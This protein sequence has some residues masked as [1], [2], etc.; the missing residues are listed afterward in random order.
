[1]SDH[2]ENPTR[3]GARADLTQTI[4]RFAQPLH[5][6][7]R[8]LARTSNGARDLLTSFPAAAVALAS[9]RS[10]SHNHTLA[11][12]LVEDGAS[13]RRI[14]D[15]LGLPHWLRRLPPEAIGAELPQRALLP[16]DDETFGRKILNALPSAFPADHSWLDMIALARSRC[17]D[18]FAVWLSASSGDAAVSSARVC[19]LAA[20]AW[21][22][23]QPALHQHGRITRRWTS[24]SPFACALTSARL[25]LAHILLKLRAEDRVAA[26]AVQAIDFAGFRFEPLETAEALA[27]E[28]RAMRHCV[29]DYATKVALGVSHIY[30][31]RK[32]GRRVATVEYIATGLGGELEL[33]QI[34]GPENARVGAPA[35]MAA[36]LLP[37]ILNNGRRTSAAPSI[38]TWRR[39]WAPYW[40]AKGVH[41]PLGPRPYCIPDQIDELCG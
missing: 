30:G 5:Q 2:L 14:A 3:A 15:A 7:L 34:C 36:R 18:E 25:W 39:F 31:M 13:L 6:R 19:V 21:F 37:A 29:G 20:Y 23:N 27:A 11:L 40:L 38:G 16:P 32:A 33:Y 1:M 9:A 28:G 17:D 26:P 22:S 8:R 10:A 41:Q 24:R 4:Q 12:A 35:A